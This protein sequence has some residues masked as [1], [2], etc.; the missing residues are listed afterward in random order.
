MP[1]TTR[2]ARAELATRSIARKFN[3]RH[4]VFLK[5][6]LGQSREPTSDGNDRHDYA[7]ALSRTEAL[8]R[9]EMRWQCVSKWRM[10]RP[11]GGISQVSGALGR[12]HHKANDSE[13]TTHEVFLSA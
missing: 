6:V 9:Y 5:F 4:R 12:D 1:P 2:E 10:R 7:G 8:N 11:T 13:M 3:E